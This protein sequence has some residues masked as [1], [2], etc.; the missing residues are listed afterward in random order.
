M[1]RAK[2]LCF[3]YG[4]KQI[5][6]DFSMAAEKGELVAIMGASGSGKTTLLRLLAGLEKPRAGELKVETEEPVVVFQE[7]RLFPWLTVEKNIEAILPPK[8]EKTEGQKAIAE[9]LAFVGLTES[10]KQKP[11]ELSGGMRSRAA[12][13]RALAY[14]TVTNARLYL[15]DEPFSALD[16]AMRAQLSA[17]LRRYMRERGATAILVT[18]STS[19]AERFADR[20]V[21][22]GE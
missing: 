2:N 3:S 18:H 15:L 16:E 4:E 14:G 8:T 1:I 5:F 12:L 17:E 6:R 22:I 11:T 9:A 21:R 13:A 7:P 10:A 19:D 20:T